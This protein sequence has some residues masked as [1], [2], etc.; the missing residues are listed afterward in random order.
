[1]DRKSFEAV[2]KTPVPQ[3]LKVF[4]WKLVQNGLGVQTN[5]LRHHLISDAT[6][7]ICGMEPEHGHHAM[8]RCTKA[9]ALRPAIWQ[10]WRL[11]DESSF[12]Y[13]GP[14]LITVLLNEVDKDTRVKLMLLFWRIW[15]HRN[16]V[17]LE[18]VNAPSLQQ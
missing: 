15:H 1:M 7:S 14:D 17:V 16:D 5:R 10:S 8:V 6:C 4:I 11:P 12:N 18:K 9:T 3:K 13:T 2:W